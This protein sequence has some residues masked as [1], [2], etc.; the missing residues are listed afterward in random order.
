MGWE[1]RQVTPAVEVL[2]P[3][4]GK[5]K[6]T[7]RSPAPTES[8]LARHCSFSFLCY[9]FPRGEWETVGGLGACPGPKAGWESDH[10][11]LSGF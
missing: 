10:P 9:P 8:L 1:V 7:R 6:E 4:L 2:G 11:G 3:W 5:A